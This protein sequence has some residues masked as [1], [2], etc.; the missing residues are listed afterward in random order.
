MK[1][2]IDV[3]GASLALLC[4]A[5][6]FFWL[7]LRIRSDMGSPV[8]F[9]QDRIGEG[10]RIFRM[11]KFRSMRET[12]DANGPPPDGERL[13]AFGQKLRA[14]SVDELPELWNVLKGEMSL[15]GPRPLLVEYLPLY[16]KEQA[17][18][19]EIRPGLTGWAQVNGRNSISWEE[20]FALDVWYVD[21]QTLWLDFK[22]IL[23][24]LKKVLGRTGVSAEG[25][26]TMVKFDG[27]MKNGR[28]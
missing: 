17:R 24:T 23:I 4:L 20:K 5:P 19:H 3:M 12:L 9:L 22:I 10:G 18:R 6:L 8:F 14:S 2:L 16:S 11:I 13:T 7:S 15:V 26:A 21:N 28:R 1:R 27:K 25:S